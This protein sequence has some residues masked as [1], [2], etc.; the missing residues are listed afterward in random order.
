MVRFEQFQKNRGTLEV[1]EDNLFEALSTF[2]SE[3]QSSAEMILE[4]IADP[5]AR[6]AGKAIMTKTWDANVMAKYYEYK[7]LHVSAV[8]IKFT[9]FDQS[10]A[11]VSGRA[12]KQATAA[13]VAPLAKTSRFSSNRC[14]SST[15]RRETRTHSARAYPKSTPAS[16]PGLGVFPASLS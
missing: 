7:Y 3:E 16:P 4:S 15:Y 1:T 2:F 12:A 13:E 14:P 6:A 9:E 8:F 5:Q 10:M 11:E